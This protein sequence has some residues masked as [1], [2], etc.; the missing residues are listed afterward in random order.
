MTK[1]AKR[2]STTYLAIL[3]ST[4]DQKYISHFTLACIVSATILQYTIRI[5]IRR[6]AQ[7]LVNRLQPVGLHVSG[8]WHLSSCRLYSTSDRFILL[9]PRNILLPPGYISTSAGY[10]LLPPDFRSVIF[11]FQPVIFYFRPCSAHPTSYIMPVIG[12]A[13]CSVPIC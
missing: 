13:N 10:I 8:P 5:K 6:I 3:Q 1:C 4:V 2:C 7:K 11:Y 12:Q 9:P